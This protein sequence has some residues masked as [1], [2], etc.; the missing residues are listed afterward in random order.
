MTKISLFYADWCG[1]CKTFKPIWDAL[2]KEFIKNNVEFKEYEDSKN[3]EIIKK[4]GIDGFPTIKI[5]KND[6]I[7]YE[8]MGERSANAILNEILPNL[9]IGGKKNKY[10]IKY[11]KF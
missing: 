9:Q 7:E 8:Y 4:E 6:G 2:K 1:H 3:E 10:F 11:S 5:K